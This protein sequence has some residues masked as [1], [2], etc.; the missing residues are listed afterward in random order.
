MEA[1]HQPFAGIMFAG[2]MLSVRL[3]LASV[4]VFLPPCPVS[5]VHSAMPTLRCFSARCLR[6]V[7]VLSN[8]FLNYTCPTCKFKGIDLEVLSCHN[9]AHVTVVCF[10]FYM[11]GVSF[12]N[13]RVEQICIL[14]H[15]GNSCAVSQS[16]LHNLRQHAWIRGLPHT[17]QFHITTGPSQ[18]P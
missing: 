4:S 18:E 1:T 7:F 11:N 14:G 13:H 10:N 12:L 16:N 15:P 2:A 8:S 17:P 9:M 3:Y 6:D 5:V